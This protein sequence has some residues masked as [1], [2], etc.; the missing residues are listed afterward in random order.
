MISDASQWVDV[1]LSWA[2]SSRV[3]EI[4][5][6]YALDGGS[7][8]SDILLTGNQITNKYGVI[9]IVSSLQEETIYHTNYCELVCY[10]ESGSML[11]A[12]LT[13]FK[14]VENDKFWIEIDVPHKTSRIEYWFG[15]KFNVTAM[16][17]YGVTN[18]ATVNVA[19]YENT[20]IVKPEKEKGI[21]VEADG[22]IGVNASKVIDS[23]LKTTSKNLTGAINEVFQSAANSNNGH[24]A[25]ILECGGTV[26]QA[27]SVPTDS[28]INNGIRTIKGGNKYDDISITG[29]IVGTCE[30]IPI[31]NATV[32]SNVYG[33]TYDEHAKA[34]DFWVPFNH[35]SDYF[36]NM[37]SLNTYRNF[38]VSKIVKEVD[39][40][41]YIWGAKIRI[42]TNTYVRA[43]YGFDK[44]SIDANGYTQ[45]G[46]NRIR[47]TKDL[48]ING[49]QMYKTEQE[50][51]KSDLTD[52]QTRF[53]SV[54]GYYKEFSN[55]WVM[56][57]G[58]YFGNL[59][60]DD[61]FYALNSHYKIGDSSG[62]YIL[63]STPSYTNT[64]DMYFT[65]FYPYN[66]K[67][68]IKNQ[69]MKKA[70]NS[71]NGTTV[72]I[73]G[74]GCAIYVPSNLSSLYVFKMTFFDDDSKYF[75]GYLSE[76]QYFHV[77]NRGTL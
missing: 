67:D 12:S 33:K 2:V 54:F 69:F 53:Y 36:F 46:A 24:K 16:Q 77:I 23:T 17:L 50:A 60:T 7:I 48:I 18:S 21:Y 13:Y 9:F 1:D 31:T 52:T 5:D 40:S 25:V 62:R 11:N 8:E 47:V 43:Y 38:T 55:D 68:A 59:L 75:Y 14:L 74:L 57:N 27:G 35:I 42:G 65:G 45:A 66:A 37:F 29:G 73:R 76:N 71:V 34:T 22:R 20:G 32:Y 63:S 41:N 26:T 28:E 39:G 70:T 72:D 61:I 6:G 49:V 58:S 64:G 4:S 19:T 3:T 15:G 44:A 30:I 51:L 56:W 10:D